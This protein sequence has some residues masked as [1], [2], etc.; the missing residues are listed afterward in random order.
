M[1]LKSQKTWYMPI[2]EYPKKRDSCVLPASS[3]P[4]TEINSGQRS[5][6]HYNLLP[7]NGGLTI[8]ANLAITIKSF[9]W[10][11]IRDT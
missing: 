6:V 11:D 4:P 2:E 5:H 10:D 3:K 8:Q 1:K 7:T 9:R